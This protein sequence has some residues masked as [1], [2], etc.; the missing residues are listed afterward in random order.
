MQF[1]KNFFILHEEYIIKTIFTIITIFAIYS[2]LI[3]SS[4]YFWLNFVFFN[5]TIQNTTQ[6]GSTST[7]TTQ[8]GS[9]ATGSIAT[10]DFSKNDYIA[11]LKS[12]TGTVDR[13]RY[14]LSF[15]SNWTDFVLQNT[16]IQN[17]LLWNTKSLNNIL[18]HSF[19]QKYQYPFSITQS[20]Y[21]VIVTQKPIP[22]NK[23]MLL[24]INGKSIWSINKTIDGANFISDLV[25]D[26]NGTLFIFPVN[27][28]KVVQPDRI[29]VDLTKY[30]NPLTLSVAIWENWNSVQSLA[31]VNP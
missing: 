21:L 24:A 11:T 29:S 28:I 5:N 20:G 17:L 27:N 30:R 18:L 10:E 25:K 13:I 4:K 19:L 3:I 23:D 16:T 6:T 1:I 7:W 31:I 8:T 14:I 12:I 22:A 26:P 2:W 9:I 15:W